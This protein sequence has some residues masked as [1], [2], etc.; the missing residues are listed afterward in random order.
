MY[1]KLLTTNIAFIIVYVRFHGGYPHHESLV[2][3]L[4]IVHR[5]YEPFELLS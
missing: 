5:F 2:I 4:D 1:I 3:L